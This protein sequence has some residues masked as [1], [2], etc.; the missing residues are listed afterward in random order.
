MM[1]YHLLDNQI[2]LFL[3]ANTNSYQLISPSLENYKYQDATLCLT[4]VMMAW[5]KSAA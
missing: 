2:Y 5:A 3:V 4:I 1:G